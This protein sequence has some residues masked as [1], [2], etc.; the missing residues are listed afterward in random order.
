MRTKYLRKRRN[1][2]FRTDPHCHWC[3]CELVLPEN[4]DVNTRNQPDNMATIDHLRSRYTLTRQEPNHTKEQRLVLSCYR[5][6]TSR[7]DKE[8]ATIPLEEL[9]RRSHAKINHM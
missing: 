2:M 5:C 7:N 8:Q 9:H 3:G 1:E 6:N 4:C